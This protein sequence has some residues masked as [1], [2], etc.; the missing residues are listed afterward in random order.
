MVGPLLIV[1]TWSVRPLPLL[2]RYI[3]RENY[4]HAGPCP[5]VRRLLSGVGRAGVEVWCLLVTQAQKDAAKRRYARDGG[6]GKKKKGAK[7]KG[8]AKSQG[9]SGG[10]GRARGHERPS[11]IKYF[12]YGATVA[13]IAAATGYGISQTEAAKAVIMEYASILGISTG[14]GL[15]A[16]VGILYWAS[17]RRQSNTPIVGSVGAAY[18]SALAAVGWKP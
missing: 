2:G 11:V 6:I 8:K 17:R 3:S 10:G 16:T 1:C 15:A 5:L 4:A 9:R 18:A 13:G 14:L 7:A 12:V